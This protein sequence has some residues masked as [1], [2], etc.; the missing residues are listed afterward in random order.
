MKRTVK[1][2]LI[3]KIFDV[4][5]AEMTL[6]RSVTEYACLSNG[7]MARS[8]G[9]IGGADYSLGLTFEIKKDKD[10]RKIKKKYFDAF[11]GRMFRFAYANNGDVTEIILPNSYLTSM[12]TSYTCGK[13]FVTLG[14]E[15]RDAPIILPKIKWGF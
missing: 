12:T 9:S 13:L 4:E 15:G 5:E 6:N 7:D 1:V 8:A 2:K 3:G 10:I 11:K 14:I